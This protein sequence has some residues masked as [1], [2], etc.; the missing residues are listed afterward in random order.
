MEKEI[1]N[2]SQLLLSDDKKNLHL[3][4][5]ILQNSVDA[6]EEYLEEKEYAEDPDYFDE[7]E[8]AP[9]PLVEP[10]MPQVAALANELLYLHFFHLFAM[11]LPHKEYSDLDYKA[12]SLFEGTVGCSPESLEPQDGCF[13]TFIGS[14]EHYGGNDFCMNERFMNYLDQLAENIKEVPHVNMLELTKLMMKSTVSHYYTR[15]I[16]VSGLGKM[17]YCNHASEA[18]VLALLRE[19]NAP[20]ELKYTDDFLIRLPDWTAKL[21]LQLIDFTDT[22]FEDFPD[23]FHLFPQLKTLCLYGTRTT[24]DYSSDEYRVP[25]D[26]F[27]RF[28]ELPGSMVNLSELTHL[29]LRRTQLGTVANLGLFPDWL[30]ELKQLTTLYLPLAILRSLPEVLAKLPRLKQ[31][32][33]PNIYLEDD[34]KEVW[35]MYHYT[36]A[37]LNAI[38]LQWF[39]ELLPDCKVETYQETVHESNTVWAAFKGIE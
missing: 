36:S 15:D 34:E 39:E 16:P 6:Y 12:G 21:D 26:A 11:D 7:D 19:D 20:H 32:F 37:S 13:A 29:D 1:A 10:D 8:E 30:A 23:N 22:T 17:Y 27:V 38:T 14:W 3:G 35:G 18:E 25:E 33:V 4:L 5:Q 28:D 24:T 2:L 9:E 31:L